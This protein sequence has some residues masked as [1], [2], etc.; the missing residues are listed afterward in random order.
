[1]DVRSR[2]AAVL[3]SALAVFGYGCS[4]SEQAGVELSIPVAFS[5]ST[6][7]GATTALVS[8]HSNYDARFLDRLR[9][10]I[11]QWTFF[12]VEGNCGASRSAAA[13]FERWAR[14]HHADR[15]EAFDDFADQ[16]RLRSGRLIA[17]CER[18][19]A[20]FAEFGSRFG[21]VNPVGWAQVAELYSVQG[22]LHVARDLF[23]EVSGLPDAWESTG[24][25]I[26]SEAIRDY[27]ETTG[28]WPVEYSRFRDG[29]LC[30]EGADHRRQ[31]QARRE[32]RQQLNLEGEEWTSDYDAPPCSSR[33]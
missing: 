18:T 28:D 27:I 2:C 25:Y 26:L 31:M 1:M 17:A 16:V 22:S 29:L 21:E 9:N 33:L 5:P 7:E 10:Q 30:P 8:S 19:K 14:R 13:L 11:E 15:L 24:E 3:I 4:D 20:N 32:A 12:A 23:L 6:S